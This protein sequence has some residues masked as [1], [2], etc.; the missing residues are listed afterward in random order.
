MPTKTFVHDTFDEAVE[1]VKEIRNRDLEHAAMTPEEETF[2]VDEI[3]LD[4][5]AEYCGYIV[6]RADTSVNREVK[7][8][9]I[10]ADEVKEK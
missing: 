5:D 7:V 10:D 8:Q 2:I 9:K 3:T 1:N 6:N 4:R